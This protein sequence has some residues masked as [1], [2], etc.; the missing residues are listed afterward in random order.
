[1]D[2]CIYETSEEYKARMVVN[3]LK[4]NKIKTFCKNLGIQNL[5]GD[6]KLFTGMDLIVGEIKVYVEKKNIG[7]AKQIIMNIPFLQNKI[8]TIENDEIQR[9]KYIAQRALLFSI[10]SLF[11]IP[12]F[13]NLEYLIYSFKR[14]LNIRYI[15][16]I[17]NISYFLFSIILCISNLNYLKFIW[18]GNIF[19]TLAFSIGKSIEL[20]K[21]KSK[22]EY[23]MII[24]IILLFVSIFIAELILNIRFFD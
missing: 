11:I 18:K 2:Y 23:L 14:R 24:P 1:M 4:K 15:L 19:F 3:I 12:F 13:F 21:K 8:H 20:N 22:L 10:A 6:S 7:K 9:N 16:S 5:Y 17:I